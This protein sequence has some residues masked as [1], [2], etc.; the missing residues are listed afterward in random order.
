MR[1]L[2]LPALMLLAAMPAVAQT[3]ADGGEA[4][5]LQQRLRALDA[6]PEFAGLAAYERLQA[7]QAVAALTEARSSQRA[8]A[9][10]IAQWR[11]ETAEI[12]SRTEASRRELTALERERSQLLVE[13]S[14]QD[15]ARARQEAE[16][17]RIQAQIQAEEAAR[18]RLAA[19]EESTARQDAE[20]VLQGV[21]S[22]EAAKLRAARQRE[23]EL[24]RREA[25]LLKSL[26]P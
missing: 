23:A 5:Q 13:A 9:T 3:P 20:N 16:R 15:A 26:E 8:S 10:Q 1:H 18:L 24:R 21:A 2:I 12:A 7:R 22:G 6:D 19:E 17:L 11:V 25:E 14:R 4:A